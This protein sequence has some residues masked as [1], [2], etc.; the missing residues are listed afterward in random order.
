MQTAPPIPSEKDPFA[1]R[2]RWTADD[3]RKVEVMGLL[4][5]G[6]YEL[7]D[8]EV[9][10]K[11]G[12]NWPHSLACK[13]TFLALTLIFGSDYIQLP[14]SVT[15]GDEDRPEPDVF[16]TKLPDR[17]YLIRGNPTPADM[18]LIVEVSDTT[19]WRDKNTK[20]KMYGGAGVSDY[21]VLD[22]NGRRLFVYRQPC[23]TGY[24]DLIEYDETQSVA[25]LAAPG[26]LMSVADLLP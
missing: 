7:I 13:R 25:P 19:L 1:D 5:P 23:A 14:V 15:V 26:S 9:V 11:L 3:C 16:V 18:R 24:A 17:D 4:E 8:G 2:K 21:W 6:T 10:S 20:A 12:Q 22:V